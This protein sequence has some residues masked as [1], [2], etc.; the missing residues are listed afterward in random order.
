[1]VSSCLRQFSFL[2]KIKLL[3]GMH[4]IPLQTKFV[5]SLF[6]YTGFVLTPLQSSSFVGPLIVGI[7]ADTTGN[8]R[9]AFF[10]LI[11]MVWSAVPVLMNIDVERGRRDASS[12]RFMS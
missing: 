8:I 12:Y 11:F 3:L 5:Q 4:F 6:T 2:Y 9:Y 1:M 7:I 10:F